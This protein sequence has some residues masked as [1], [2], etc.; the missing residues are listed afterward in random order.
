MNRDVFGRCRFTCDE[1]LELL[2][3]DPEMNISNVL[4]DD[5]LGLEKYQF[6]TRQLCVKF[7]EPKVYVY[8]EE[9]DQGIK[10][11]DK[12]NQSQWHMPDEY[13]NL[14]IAQWILSQC[15]EEHE[16]Q[17]VAQELLL[18]QDRDLF[19]LLRYLKYMVDTFRQNNVIWGV[20]RGSS[21]ASYVLFLIGVHRIDSIYYQL[22][23]TEFLK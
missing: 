21:V 19:D 6:G 15:Q 22:E 1:I 14:D 16:L 8:Y 18:F 12:V 4:T 2:Y 10:E 20:G 23:I 17:R 13:K 11:F 5:Y 7:E 3:S 9:N